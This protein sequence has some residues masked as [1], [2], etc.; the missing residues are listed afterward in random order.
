MLRQKASY[1]YDSQLRMATANLGPVSGD[2]LVTAGYGYHPDTRRVQTLTRPIAGGEAFVGTQTL[3]VAGRLDALVWQRGGTVHGSYDYTLDAVGRRETETRADG[4]RLEYSYNDRGEISGAVRKRSAD[5]S[6]RPDW[7]H[8]YTYDDSGN[9]KSTLTPEGQTLYHSQGAVSGTQDYDRSVSAAQSRWLRGRANAQAA[10]SVDGQAAEREGELWRRLLANPAAPEAQR[11]T[12]TATRPDLTPEPP[13]VV[14]TV[15]LPASPTTWRFDERGNLK[16]D[17]QWTYTWD[18][19]N[20]LIAQEQKFPGIAGDGPQPVKR[21]EFG[22]DAKGRRI[23]K[24]VLT[25]Q[26]QS[27]G[28]LVSGTWTFA[29]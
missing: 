29:Q 24:R 15:T 4:T 2:P 23:A 19:E 12:I 13:P 16:S 21:L 25:N 26:R 6:T 28:S 11:V 14:Q 10:I 17:A 22:Y 18:M 9:P 20:R 7:T 3:D 8:G 1:T 27:N 5:N